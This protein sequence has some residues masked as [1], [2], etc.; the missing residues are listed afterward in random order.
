MPSENILTFLENPSGN[1]PVVV[2]PSTGDIFK[3]DPVLRKEFQVIHMKAVAPEGAG[4]ISWHI[5]G[6]LAG[7]TKTPFV[8]KWHLVQ[9]THTVQVKAK[10]KISEKIKFYVY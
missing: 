9:G 4:I 7:K 1:R 2:F 8:F 10:D 5:D 6:Q 3:V